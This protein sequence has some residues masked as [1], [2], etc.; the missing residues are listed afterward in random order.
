MKLNRNSLNSVNVTRNVSIDT[1]CDKYVD[2]MNDMILSHM[3]NNFD[4]VGGHDKRDFINLV[5]S[6]NNLSVCTSLVKNKE[7]VY[8]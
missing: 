1:Q 6:D 5:A 3:L 4:N 7:R 2:T 8:R